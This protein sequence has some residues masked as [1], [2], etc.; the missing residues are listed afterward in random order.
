MAGSA[1]KSFV[2]LR[3]GNGSC[4][5]KYWIENGGC[6]CRRGW[7]RVALPLGDLEG[8]F[9]AV[10]LTLLLASLLLQSVRDEVRGESLGGH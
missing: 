10:V 2:A 7:G 5:G 8:G 1:G 6:F 9:R 3:V 4:G